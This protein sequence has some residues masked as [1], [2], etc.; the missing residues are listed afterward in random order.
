MADE[1]SIGPLS[2]GWDFRNQDLNPSA[3]LYPDIRDYY[4]S[5]RTL[6]RLKIAVNKFYEKARRKTHS[7]TWRAICLESAISYYSAEQLAQ[8]D[9]IPGIHLATQLARPVGIISVVARIPELDAMIPLP[10]SYGDAANMSDEDLF[11]LSLHAMDNRIFHSPITGRHG[12]STIPA[13]GDIIEVDFENRQAR[14]GGL[15]IGVLEKG[16]GM[17]PDTAAVETT[18][19]QDAIATAGSELSTMEAASQASSDAQIEEMESE[20]DALISEYA[21]EAVASGHFPNQETAEAWIR[22][23]VTTGDYTPPEN[24]AAKSQQADKSDPSL[25]NFMSR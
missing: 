18:E 9:F 15:Y 5:D 17:I 25:E 13:P 2:K 20:S 10:S 3:P 1:N 23:S 22:N 14:H 7:G 16:I 4:Q 8:Q 19:A 12:I 6:A 21:S 24:L 11:W